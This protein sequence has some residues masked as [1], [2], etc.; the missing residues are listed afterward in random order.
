MDI[1]LTINGHDFFLQK[2][3]YFR[4]TFIFECLDK[5]NNVFWKDGFNSLLNYNKTTNNYPNVKDNFL[6]IPV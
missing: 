1:L 2:L 3:Y 6:N 4:D 5:A